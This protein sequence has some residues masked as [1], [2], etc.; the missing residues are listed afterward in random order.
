MCSFLN[1]RT[2][3]DHQTKTGTKEHNCPSCISTSLLCSQR[4]MTCCQETL[5]RNVT[6]IFL[7]GNAR[8]ALGLHAIKPKWMLDT[9]GIL[10][11]HY[12]SCCWYWQRM[13]LGYCLEQHN[14][15][16]WQVLMLY[17]PAKGWGAFWWWSHREV[18]EMSASTDIYMRRRWGQALE[19]GL[20]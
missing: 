17:S 12:A 8:R 2:D 16:S 9:G 20:V 5:A 18:Q 15:P 1:H 3:F 7:K 11:W 4:T 19:E 13:S 10:I 14:T 6:L